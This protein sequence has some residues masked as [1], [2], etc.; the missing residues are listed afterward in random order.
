MTISKLLIENHVTNCYDNAPSTHFFYYYPAL[1]YYFGKKQMNIDLYTAA[2]KSL[3]YKP[4]SSA[5]NYD[6]IV[7]S[8]STNNYLNRYETIYTNP[9]ERFKILVRKEK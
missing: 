8:I 7:D 4:F 9:D 2:Q 1:E 6:C 5:D 3:R